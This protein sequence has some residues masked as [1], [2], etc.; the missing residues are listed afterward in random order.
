MRYAGTGRRVDPVGHQAAVGRVKSKRIDGGKAV[1]GSREVVPGLPRLAIFANIGR[2]VRELVGEV[3]RWVFVP[4]ALGWP[5]RDVWD[6]GDPG[7]RRCR[8]EGATAPRLAAG[9]SGPKKR[10]TVSMNSGT[11]I[12]FDK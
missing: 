5:H 12:G 11:G 1:A 8:G 9:I 7:A 2:K 10:R 4:A 6:A 3:G